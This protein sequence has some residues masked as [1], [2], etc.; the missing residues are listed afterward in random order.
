MG[1]TI[2]MWFWLGVSLL[3]ILNGK[4]L[5]AV[6]LYGFVCASACL[7]AEGI[8]LSKKAK[9][10]LTPAQIWMS[11]R[12]RQRDGESEALEKIVLNRDGL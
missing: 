2:W 6:H 5:E 10:R 3:F 8:H 11:A 1:F 4:V 12:E 7:C 9:H